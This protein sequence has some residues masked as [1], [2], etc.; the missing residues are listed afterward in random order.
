MMKSWPNK[1]EQTPDGAVSSTVAVCLFIVFV[2][3][4]CSGCM[5]W[6]GTVAGHVTGKVLDQTTKQPV[7][8]AKLFD[9]RYPRQIVITSTDGSYDFPYIMGWYHV[10]MFS[11][12]PELHTNQFLV[13]EATGYYTAEV[14]MPIDNEWFNRTN[15]LT[16]KLVR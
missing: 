2:T 8:G 16:P 7:S 5:M 14:Y 6:R 4:V 15:Y 13:I 3:L 11:P 10:P 1:L 12:G 9:K